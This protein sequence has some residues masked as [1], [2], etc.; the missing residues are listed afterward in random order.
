[1]KNESHQTTMS[2]RLVV[3][4]CRLLVRIFFGR[5]E[6]TGRKNVPETGGGVLI[7]WH[8]NGLID[9]GLILTQFPRPIVFGA[10]HGL[11]KWPLL[12]LLMRSM[13]T[14]AIFRKEDVA[15][16][17]DDSERRAANQ[18]SIDALARAVVHGRFAALFPEGLSHDE[19]YPMELKTGAARLYYRALELTEDATRPVIIPVGLH[20]NKKGVFGSSALVSFHPPLELSPELA[21]A[22]SGDESEEANRRRYRKLTAELGR[23]LHEVVFATDNW[24][25]HHAMQR[26]RKLIGAERAARAGVT[27]R[28]PKMVERVLAFSRLRK[29]YNIRARTHPEETQKLV[30]RVQAYDEDLRALGI[31][32]HE[33]DENPRLTSPWLT[34]I[35]VLQAILVWL[36]LPTLLVIGFVV[37]LPTALAVSAL[38]KVASKAYKDEASVKVLVGAVAFP[39]TWLVVSLLVAWGQ[40]RLHTLYPQ[41]PNAPAITGVVAF[42]LSALGGAVA[43]MYQRWVAATM[44]ALR[45]RLTRARRSDTIRRLREERSTLY[46][47]LMRLAEGLDIPGSPTPD[48]RVPQAPGDLR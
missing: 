22:P 7:S 4:F 16:D 17:T 28:R 41:I 43:L 25:V 47:Q 6:V 9:P 37:N 45:V 42:V 33:L 8:P 5:V 48:R 44:H 36:V 26:A 18:A 15:S 23:V 21:S 27:S 10:R 29:G 24:R 13:N 38:A 46:D 19:P 12:G 34:G 14:V 35:L 31:E 1:L 20:Y 2:Y 11:F 40:T 32:D 3:W 30:A 39:L